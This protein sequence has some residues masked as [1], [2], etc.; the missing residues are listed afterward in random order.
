[1]KMVTLIAHTH[2]IPV[3]SLFSFLTLT[4]GRLDDNI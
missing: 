3:F 2:I 1:M 4:F